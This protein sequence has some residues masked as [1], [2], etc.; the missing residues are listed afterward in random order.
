MCRYCFEVYQ[1]ADFGGAW[2]GWRLRG[3]WLISP[4]GD[5]INAQRLAGILF[6]ERVR[7]PKR[8]SG[9]GAK[10]NLSVSVYD[11]SRTRPNAAATASAPATR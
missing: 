11:M 4:A 6:V 5:R 9:D 3:A 7:K 1:H 8:F 10:Q 2:L